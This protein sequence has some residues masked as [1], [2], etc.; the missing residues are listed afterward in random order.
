[1]KCQAATHTKAGTPWCWS[2]AFLV[3]L[4]F[5]IAVAIGHTHASITPRPPPRFF[6]LPRPLPLLLIP[7]LWIQGSQTR[8]DCCPN[9]TG[10]RHRRACFVRVDWSLGHAHASVVGCL[11]MCVSLHTGGPDFFKHGQQPKHTAKARKLLLCVPPTHMPGR[12]PCSHM[13]LSTHTLPY[14]QAIK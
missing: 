14:T 8:L 9:K 12:S 4:F 6:L 13:S 11:C 7:P 2:Q 1:M 10:P 5:P 3:L